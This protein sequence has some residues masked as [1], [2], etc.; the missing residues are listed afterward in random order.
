MTTKEVDT[1]IVGGGQA[2][3]AVSAHLRR[4]DIPHV[5]L[6]R[7]RIAESWRSRRWDSLVANGPAWHDRFPALAFEGDAQDS[8]VSKDRIVAYFEEFAHKIEAPIRCGV[9]VTRVARQADRGGFIVETSE[10]RYNAKRVVAATGAFQTPLIPSVIPLNSGLTQLHSA[11]YRNADQ[12]PKGSVLVVGAGSSGAQIAEDLR[13][14][15]R[16][17]YLSVGPHHR[18]P[19]AYRGRDYCWWLGVL[20]QWD[21]ANRDPKAAHVTISV[22]G[23][24]GGKTVDFRKLAGTGIMLLGM[25]DRFDS[26]R[27]YFAGDLARNIAA[28]DANYLSVL[29][30]ADA[31]IARNGLDFPE[32]PGARTVLP[33]PPALTHPIR[34]LD[35][36]KAGVTTILWATGYTFDFGWLKVDAFDADG[37]PQHQRGVST[38]LGLYFIGLPWQSRRGSSFIWG[39]WHDAKFLAD[40][41]EIQRTYE[42][43]KPVPAKAAE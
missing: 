21:A 30:E 2:G 32:E 39:V 28:G 26:G 3:L 1:V 8:F 42:A 15:G 17:V 5:I 13:S 24:H 38:E 29:N 31:Y 16:N 40:Q 27:L 25:T 41:I 22:S 34:S 36:T 43:Y 23:A 7:D 11:Q 9:D 14:A 18:P 33:D 6:E 20:G 12:L 35:L 19:R 37:M 4:R 10:G